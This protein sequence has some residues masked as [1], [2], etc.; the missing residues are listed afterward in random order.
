MRSISTTVRI[1]ADP[2]R[3]W[4]ILTDLPAYADWN[5]FIREAAGDPAEG[6]RLNLR[7]FP[8]KGRPMTFKPKVL[9]AAPGQELAWIGHLLVPGI[10]DGT[11]RF[12]LTALE[13]GGTELVHS[14]DFRG[15]LV[16][17]FGKVI[18]RSVADFEA[19]NEALKKRAEG[20]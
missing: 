8:A 12:R 5:P 20:A 16:P 13:D 18:E 3:V 10:F 15:L 19:L 11:H 4:E 7:M 2:A 9:A 6:A 1:D 14:E 17:L